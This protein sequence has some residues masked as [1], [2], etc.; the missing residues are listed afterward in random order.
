MSIALVV[1]LTFRNTE[2]TM[3]INACKFSQKLRTEIRKNKKYKYSLKTMIDTQTI[4][5]EIYTYISL[6]QISELRSAICDNLR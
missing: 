1:Q 2:R 6:Y 4:E 5:S 3:L